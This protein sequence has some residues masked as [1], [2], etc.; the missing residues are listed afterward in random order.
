MTLTALE[1]QARRYAR[2]D[3]TAASNDQMHTLVQSAVDKFARDVNG[4]PMDVHLPISAEFDTET[5]FAI[6]VTIVE[7]GSQTVD[8]DVPITSTQREDASGSTV[9]SDLQTALRAMTGAAGTETVT[10]TKFYF[11]IDFKQ[12][13]TASGDSIELSAPD[14]VQ[15][16]SALE[17]LGLS[18]GTTTGSTTVTG[19]FP[20]DCTRYVTMPTDAIKIERVEWDGWELSQ[21]GL[22]HVQ[23]SESTGD[24]THYAVR[25]R[26][27]YLVPSPDRD[28][29]L[30]VWFRGKPSN[31]DFKGYQELNIEDLTYET[32]TGLS[33][34][35]AYAFQVAVDG[36][37]SSEY[38]ITT[39]TDTSY[40]AVIALMNVQTDGISTAVIT[41]NGKFRMKSDTSGAGSTVDLGAGVG[42][43]DLFGA[44]T[45][46][47]SFETAKSADISVPVEVPLDYEEALIWLTAMYLC[48]EAFDNEQ[49]N[50]C[51]AEY[52][53]I[54]RK[55][56]VDYAN[57][58]TVIE[59][60]HYRTYPRIPKVGSRV[61]FS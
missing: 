41:E 25:G 31:I 21:V 15:Y 52:S 39:G 53:D 9:A 59:D 13:N 47:S 27:I 11:T 37:F 2:I 20:E 56:R 57:M 12:G 58:N 51:R 46:F 61:G 33:A 55:Y 10:W 34:S 28:D 17:L 6:H 48:R 3:T 30:D 5:Y 18:S 42:Q 40:N 36:G 29:K 1:A 38:T 16:A 14:G 60:N 35:T 4:F 49:A 24:P 8:A 43:T 44:L 54:M 32:A 23:S 7:N 45:G 22:E 26:R 19:G 50:I